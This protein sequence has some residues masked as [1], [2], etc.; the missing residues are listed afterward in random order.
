MRV[1]SRIQCHATTAPTDA[2][3]A[4]ATATRTTTAGTRLFRRKQ[5]AISHM[6]LQLHKALMNHAHIFILLVQLACTSTAYARESTHSFAQL[7]F[8]RVNAVALN[9]SLCFEKTCSFRCANSFTI[10]ACIKSAS[11]CRS[12]G[13]YSR[14]CVCTRAK[15]L[16]VRDADVL[17]EN[18]CSICDISCSSGIGVVSLQRITNYI[19]GQTS[20]AILHAFCGATSPCR[21]P[22]LISAPF[23][24][25]AKAG[26]Q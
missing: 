4:A 17:V 18:M 8:S 11:F 9:T 15:F 23:V 21:V 5:A 12:A 25:A 19:P 7:Y 14:P 6:I 3:A 20:I 22:I 24:H 26:L 10:L 2:A 1:K 16:H 13:K